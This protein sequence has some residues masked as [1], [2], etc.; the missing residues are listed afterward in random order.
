MWL[1]GQAKWKQSRELRRSLAIEDERLV[2]AVSLIDYDHTQIAAEGFRDEAI[3]QI[4]QI[5]ERYQLDPE[6]LRDIMHELF[7]ALADI[8][9]PPH[10]ELETLTI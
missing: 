4:A 10:E 6:I 1:P 3:E 8:T 9:P 5:G 2:G 7:P